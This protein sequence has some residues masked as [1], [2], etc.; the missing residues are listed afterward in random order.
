[1]KSLPKLFYVLP[2]IALIGE[3]LYLTTV[4]NQPTISPYSN[5]NYYLS[6]LTKALQISQLKYQ[7]L[8]VYD[9]R[10]EIEFY[11]V[12]SPKHSFKVIISRQKP[13]LSQVAA[14]QKL[15]KI[16]NIEGRQINFVDLSSKHSYATF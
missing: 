10:Q 5:N 6:E 3:L 4:N 13:P 2:L 9:F 12:D 14:L 1:M 7:Q 11:I 16:A 15:I 8:N